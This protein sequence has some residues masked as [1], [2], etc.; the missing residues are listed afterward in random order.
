MESLIC[1]SLS[2]PWREAVSSGK[3]WKELKAPSD[4]PAGRWSKGDQ[5]SFGITIVGGGYEYGA[6][7]LSTAQPIHA[8]VEERPVG[9]SGFICQYNGYRALRLSGVPFHPGSRA[10]LPSGPEECRFY[11]QD[12]RKSQSLLICDPLAQI[13]LKHFRWSAF[14]N[15]APFEKEGH[16]LW[17]PVIVR[18]STT[19]LPHFA[20]SLSPETA[21]DLTGL[22]RRS[23]RTVVFF[24]GLHAGATV[25]HLHVQAIFCRHPLAIEQA[26]TVSYRGFSLLEGY[27]A[28]A[29]CF[30]VDT[31][32]EEIIRFI[33][34]MERMKIPFNLI[35]TGQRIFILPRNIE[36]EVVAEFPG[37]VLGSMELAGKI[38]TADREVYHSIDTARIERG[39]KKTTLPIRELIDHWW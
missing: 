33:G 1:Q 2:E 25:N 28:E 20:Q 4:D 11:C 19:V 34:R 38:V 26:P 13:R 36:H 30:S 32:A 16:L 27:P 12:P 3:T 24:N 31:Q 22:L 37:G 17:V 7:N 39:F 18:G 9:C 8:A 35:G 29:L 15:A 23:D 10:D 21:E 5:V 6:Y 14:Y